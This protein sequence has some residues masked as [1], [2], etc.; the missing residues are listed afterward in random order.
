MIRA[1]GTVVTLS[2][3]KASGPWPDRDHARLGDEANYAR[4]AVRDLGPKHQPVVTFTCPAST[5]TS[6]R[7]PG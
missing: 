3:K 4:G 6:R 5:A 7:P 2:V 1:Q